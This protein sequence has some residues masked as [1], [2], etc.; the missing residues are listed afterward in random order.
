MNTEGQPRRARQLK[1]RGRATHAIMACVLIGL[2]GCAGYRIGSTLPSDIKTIH[3]PTFTNKAKQPL[4]EVQATSR[5]VSEF[6]RDGTLRITG[7]AEA[8][9]I[10]EVTITDLTLTPLRYKRNDRRTPNEYRMKLTASYKLKRTETDAIIGESPKI[11][12]ETTFPYAG[13]MQAAI[14]TALPDAADDLGRRLVES[15]VELW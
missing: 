3:I 14:Q 5:A 13:G 11:E 1:S 7:A 2:A 9:V 10:L 6:Q 8:D 15:V 4:I 12:G